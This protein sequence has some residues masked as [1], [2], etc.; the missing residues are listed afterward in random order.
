MTIMSNKRLI[1]ELD[2]Y[3]S[4]VNTK[5]LNSNVEDLNLDKLKPIVDMVAK[6]RAAYINELM[7][8][9]TS[10]TE[11]GV[12]AEQIE[13]LR[14]RRVEFTELVKATSALEIAI[15]RGYLDVITGN[16]APVANTA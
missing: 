11:A 14:A 16:I 13:Q 5:T 1:L 3:R 8:I 4:D 12:A 9:S 2:K 7:E 10:Q 15:K 6:S